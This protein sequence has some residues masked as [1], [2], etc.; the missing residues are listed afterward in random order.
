MSVLR[1]AATAAVIA[2]TAS[3]TT[4]RPPPELEPHPPTLEMHPMPVE[5]GAVGPR[6]LEDVGPVACKLETHTAVDDTVEM[7]LTKSAPTDAAERARF[8]VRY[9]AETLTFP[10][11]DS[12]RVLAS[13]ETY[14]AR[15]GG[16]IVR[17]SISLGVRPSHKLMDGMVTLTELP[18]A[19]VSA[20]VG[21]LHFQPRLDR[22]TTPVGAWS[23]KIPC[24]DLAPSLFENLSPTEGHQVWLDEKAPIALSAT[25]DGP[26]RLTISADPSLGRFVASK[27]ETHAKSLR[28]EMVVGDALIAGWIPKSATHSPPKSKPGIV[29]GRT[30]KPALPQP[31]KVTGVECKEPL[32]LAAPDRL[33]PNAELVWIGEVHPGT[34]I[35]VDDATGATPDSSW[36]AVILRG[37][38]A[39]V[40]ILVKSESLETCA[41][42]L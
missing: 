11:G 34:A 1:T 42:R 37:V 12:E 16:F 36:H 32:A 6:Q 7:S 2:S 3:C 30:L 8:V 26:P 35:D 15:L 21:A 19:I 13:V 20:E 39:N 17:K 18:H 25:F 23:E 24:E 10:V 27:L 38:T 9:N 40:P 22:V 14:G 29:G 41:K 33:G 5:P 4:P 28:V 31:P